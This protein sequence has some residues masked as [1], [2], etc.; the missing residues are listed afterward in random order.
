METALL[1]SISFS[2]ASLKEIDL[3]KAVSI[4][5]YAFSGDEYYIC[6]DDSMQYPAVSDTGYY[7]STQHAPVLE[8]VDLTNAESVGEYAFALCKQL[9]EVVLG[10][11]I[12]VLPQYAFAS[13]EL[14]ETINLDKIVSVGDYAFQ[15]TEMLVQIDLSAAE[16]IGKY[17]F[18]NGKALANAKLNP[19]GSE[20]CKGAFAYCGLLTGAENLNAVKNVGDYAFAYTAITEAD[21]SAAENIGMQAFIKEELTPFKVT[22][23]S[24]LKTL[25]DNPFAM[26]KLEPFCVTEVKNFNGVDYESKIYTYE[27]SPTVQVID[28]SL[29]AKI[30]T[31]LELITYAGTNHVDAQVAEDTVRI[32]A[33]AFAGSDVQM[34]TM[35]H[36][37][38]SIGHKA[39]FDCRKLH[40]VVFGSY[41]APIL[42]EEF[43]PTYYE[44]FE[45][46][47]GTGDFGTYQDYSGNEIQINGMGLLP[48]YMWNATDG[49]YSNVFYGA[50]FVDYVG[51]V[52]DK[53]TMVRPAN[54][55]NYD[56]FV[57]AQY[58]D[59][60]I[61]G[62]KA[63][64]EVTLAAIAAIKAIP[65][66]VTY[67]NRA[68]VEAAR[69]AYTKIATI[70]QQSLVVNY[71]DLVSAEQR[72]ISLTP[73]DETTPNEGDAENPETDG[74]GWI[75]V[76]VVA[77]L[78]A[79]GG[80]FALLSAVKRKKTK[81][82][83]AVAEEVLCEETAEQIPVCEEVTAEVCEESA[84]AETAEEQ[85]NDE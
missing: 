79:I 82:A 27:I 56:S 81:A 64:D 60:A 68:V 84:P 26:C 63:P 6:L 31:G 36:S 7:M 54:G 57:L 40:T 8:R 15:E 25:G 16:V 5:D 59:L 72:I 58:F 18:V 13:C 24:E 3:S 53:L 28:G 44:S 47:P 65:A 33:M 48:Y 9:K 20:V 41:E 42:E 43:D 70:E 66:R 4:G 51:Y 22:L 52:T 55:V 30:N 67:E 69:A 80:A 19:A 12:T 75:V 62:A 45:H 38:V 71:A 21:L 37:T 2:C 85:A 83:D 34:V 14:L 49:M 35:P 17:A 78:V 50:N 29:Y 46:I 73:T 77:V 10:E 32:T 23:G 39:F 61:D 76:V 1:R 11:K 74:K